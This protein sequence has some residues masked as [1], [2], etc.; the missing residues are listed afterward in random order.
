MSYLGVQRF[1]QQSGGGG[2]STMEVDAVTR[3]GKSKHGGVPENVQPLFHR[4][5]PYM[6][7]CVKR[8][9]SVMVAVFC[10]C[11]PIGAGFFILPGLVARSRP[12]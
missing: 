9:F 4:V 2:T 6:F 1:L 10:S 12:G 8:L 11:E 7:Q 3:D 5:V